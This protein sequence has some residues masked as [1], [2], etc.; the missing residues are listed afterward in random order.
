MTLTNAKLQRRQFF[1]TALAAAGG[2]AA[3]PA[4]NGLGSS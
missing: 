4:L 2:V 1:R 3:L